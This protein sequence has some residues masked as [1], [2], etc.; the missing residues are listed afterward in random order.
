[1]NAEKTETIKLTNYYNNPMG[2]LFCF[3][4]VILFIVGKCFVKFFLIKMFQLEF[5]FLFKNLMISLSF[6]NLTSFVLIK[7]LSLLPVSIKA[8]AV[9]A[10]FTVRF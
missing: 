8:L 7:L 4:D 2:R 6:N 5:L 10:S 3:T 1:M 9:Y